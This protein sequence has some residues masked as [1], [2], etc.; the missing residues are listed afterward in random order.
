MVSFGPSKLTI[1]C[2]C[3]I[4]ENH[5]HNGFRFGIIR[6]LLKWIGSSRCLG[7]IAFLIF[8]P[9]LGDSNPFTI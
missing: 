5:L 4:V 1:V 8:S 9:V 3:E 2:L 7:S 6:S